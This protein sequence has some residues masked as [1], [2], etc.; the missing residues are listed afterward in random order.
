M[1]VA[2]WIVCIGGEGGGKT[3]TVV[4]EEDEDGGDDSD[5]SDEKD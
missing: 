1:G 2:I 3:K 5:E 4:F